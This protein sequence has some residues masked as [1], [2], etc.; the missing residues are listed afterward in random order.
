MKLKS[1]LKPWTHLLQIES[2]DRG[3]KSV[4][5]LTSLLGEGD[6]GSFSG[7]YADGSHLEAYLGK[8]VPVEI[9]GDAYV[10]QVHPADTT[11]DKVSLGLSRCLSPSFMKLYESWLITTSVSTKQIFELAGS[12]ASI[13][14]HDGR[15]HWVGETQGV[16]FDVNRITIPGEQPESVLV[17]IAFK[18]LRSLIDH[19]GIPEEAV[20]ISGYAK[21]GKTVLSYDVEDV[22]MKD[23]F[24]DPSEHAFRAAGSIVHLGDLP[25]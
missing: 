13:C 5:G 4:R 9:A 16:R 19:P 18:S 1:P 6:S 22:A 7:S 20:V 10:S 23:V 2:V 12:K 11:I 3:S 17:A 14:Y 8:T 25:P 24:G 15:Y 21:N